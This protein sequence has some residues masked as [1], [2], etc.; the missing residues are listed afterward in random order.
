MKLNEL[1]TQIT[2]I[3]YRADKSSC[4]ELRGVTFL[5]YTKL[6]KNKF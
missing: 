1:T 4:A 2:M 5:T 6:I 3:T